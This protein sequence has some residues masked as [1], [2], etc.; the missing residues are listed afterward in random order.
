M[1]FSSKR[2]T[3]TEAAGLVEIAAIKWRTAFAFPAL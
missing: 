1:W 3:P 2:T